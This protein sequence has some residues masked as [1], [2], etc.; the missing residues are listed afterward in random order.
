MTKQEIQAEYQRRVQLLQELMERNELDGVVLSSTAQQGNQLCVKYFS[1][2]TL[3]TRRAYIFCRSGEV[4][5]LVLPTV[6][7]VF[8]ARKISW[9]PDEQIICGDMLE[10]LRE[11]LAGMKRVGWYLPDDLPFSVHTALEETGA[12]FVDVTEQLTTAR[13]NKSAY[14]IQLTKETSRLA[15]D[16]FAYILRKMRPGVTEEELIGAAEGYLRAHG[17]S[18]SLVLTRSQKPHS[19]IT[20]A[21]PVPIEEDGMFVYSA[22]V[23]GRGGYWTQMVRPVFMTREAQPEAQYILAVGKKAEAAGV[24]LLRPGYR[25]CDVSDAIEA[26][27]VANGLRTGV[28]SGH[29][30]GPDLGDAVDIGSSNHMEIV[31]NMVVTLHPSIVSDSD[32]LL[33]GNTFLTTESDPICLTP[34]YNDSP[35]LEDLLAQLA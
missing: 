14:E 35:F 24:K 1:N 6:G 13:A 12:E 2:Y 26:E 18:D 17:A 31:P 20:R 32:G 15:A 29:G 4:P 28:W 25:L 30:M 34:D 19:F 10:I 7:Q 5:Y 22:E 9:L 16:S 27:V 3:N 11:K 8:H 33:Y 21:Q 23:A